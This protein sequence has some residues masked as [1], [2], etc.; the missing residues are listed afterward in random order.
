MNYMKEHPDARIKIAQM[1]PADPVA[2][3]VLKGADT[4]SLIEAVN[5]ILEEARQ[6]GRLAEI[7]MKYFGLDLTQP[8]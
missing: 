6:D 2:Y 5:N 7:S 8:D 3:P 1:M 4:E